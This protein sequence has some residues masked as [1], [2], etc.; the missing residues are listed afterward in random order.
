M[1]VLAI[2]DDESYRLLI[3]E[4][5]KLAVPQAQIDM[6]DPVAGGFPGADFDLG[7]YD[8]VLLDYRLGTENGLEW[9][10]RFKARE[11]C[12]AV[13]MIT[14]EGS[15]SVVVQAIKAGADDYLPK[16]RLDRDELRRIV[17]D[18]MTAKGLQSNDET[19]Q[20]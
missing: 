4:M 19:V 16:E 10:R 13:V 5:L 8:L 3:A 15:E 18:A 7:A 12:P 17:Q 14:G 2:D 11:H 6:Y 1:R 20:L 9:L